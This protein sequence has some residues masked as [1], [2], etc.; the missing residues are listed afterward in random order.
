M[1]EKWIRE[2]LLSYA[3]FPDDEDTVMKFLGFSDNDTAIWI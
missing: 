2:L 3:E 1:L